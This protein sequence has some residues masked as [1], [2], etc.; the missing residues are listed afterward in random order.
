MAWIRL[1]TDFVNNDEVCSLSVPVRYAIVAILLYIKAHGSKGSV[2]ATPTQLARSVDGVT[3]T[4][5]TQALETRFFTVEGKTISVRNWHK[6]QIDATAAERKRNQRQ[7]DMQHLL[8]GETV[9][10]ETDDV[11]VTS[12]SH[13]CH[14]DSTGQDNTKD[15]NISTAA[16]FD[17]IANPPKPED[18]MDQAKLQGFPDLDSEEFIAHYAA[19]GWMLTGGVPC[20]DWRGLITKWRKNK[21]K[22]NRDKPE[23]KSRRSNKEQRVEDW[24]GTE[25]SKS[26]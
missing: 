25:G 18:V 2:R 3:V 10:G 26:I 5:V 15:I 11:T 8:A 13:A 6:F 9:G 1:N 17:P 7:R 24:T 19:K 12:V 21:G 23:S 14:A 22:F 20:Q 4:N 16:D